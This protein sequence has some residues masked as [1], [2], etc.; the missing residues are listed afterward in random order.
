MGA[1]DDDIIFQNPNHQRS[2]LSVVSATHSRRE[3]SSLWTKALNSL[4]DDTLGPMGTGSAGGR[5]VVG[6]HVTREVVYGDVA[7]Q[8]VDPA[9]TRRR[10]GKPCELV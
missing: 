3:T 10:S 9:P 4:A 8:R 2:R 1:G 6:I 7:L 5:G